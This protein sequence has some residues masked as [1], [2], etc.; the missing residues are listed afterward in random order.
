MTGFPVSLDTLIGYVR[1]LHP[2]GGALEHL[3]D[4]VRVS[5]EL[6]EQ[7]D[8][9]IGHFVDQARRSGASWSQI[10]TSMGVSKQAAQKRFVPRTDAADLLP[11]GQEL[12]GR[13]APR[14]K[15]VLSAAQRTAAAAGAAEVSDA[16]LT[17]ALPTVP[18][19]V[20]ATV[21]HGA[22]ITDQQ[23]AEAVG[24]AGVPGDATATDEQLAGIA[25]DQTGR[26]AL[27]GALK[28]ALRLQHNYIG[29]EHLLLGVLLAGGPAA[30]AL[31]RLGLDVERTEAAVAAEVTRI[32]EA[33]GRAGS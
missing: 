6:D 25:F 27:R 12:F 32:A 21:L 22:G 28:A 1:T 19:A 4:A 14:A 23:V 29:T 9:L 5:A 11:P 26:D 30:G 24:V 31:A 20:A 13:F 2:D 18:G 3:G 7:S 8:A 15:T 10:G 33:L 17:A 16:H